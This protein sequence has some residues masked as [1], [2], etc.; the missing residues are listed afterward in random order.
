MPQGWSD[1]DVVK[2]KLEIYP[3]F[4]KPVSCLQPGFTCWLSKVF[5]RYKVASLFSGI[6][7]LELGLAAFGPLCFTSQM[8][9]FYYVLLFLR[10]LFLAEVL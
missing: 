7:G 3:W 2:D 6:L 5:N 9:L 10:Y 8:G 4:R 1:I